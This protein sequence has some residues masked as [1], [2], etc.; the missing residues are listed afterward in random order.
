M[1]LEL[2]IIVIICPTNK[3]VLSGIR[4]SNEH[5]QSHRNLNSLVPSFNEC[6]DRFLARLRPLA[7]GKTQVPMKIEFTDLTL[8]VI[9]KV[10]YTK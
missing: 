1:V 7:D 10:G 6:V 3:R 5:P 9:S 8:D 4:G 2:I